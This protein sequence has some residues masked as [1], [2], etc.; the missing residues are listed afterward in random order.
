MVPSGSPRATSMR[1][2]PP[3]SG[4]VPRSR[5]STTSS[6]WSATRTSRPGTITTVDDEDL[7]TVGDCRISS[8]GWG[9]PRRSAATGRLGR[10]R[11]GVRRASGH[12]RRSGS[13]SYDER[14]SSDATAATCSRPATTRSSG[15]GLQRRRRCRDARPRGRRPIGAKPDRTRAG[16]RPR[17]A[18]RP[19]GALGHGCA[20]TPPAR[21]GAPP[22]ST[23][24][25][26][27][28]TA[29]ASRRPNP[30][31]HPWV[32]AGAPH[33]LICAIETARG[34]LAATEIATRPASAISRWAGSTC[35][36][37]STPPT[38]TCRRSTCARRLVGSRAARSRSHRSIASSH[39][40]RRRRPA[41]AG[42]LAHSLGF[43][44]KSAI[45]PRQLSVASRGL[46][47][48][49]AGARLGVRGARTP[50]R[51]AG[52][53]ALRLPDGDFVDVHS[54]SGP[55]CAAPRRC[56]QRADAVSQRLAVSA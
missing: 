31:R 25:P 53:A 26:T 49:R 47:P 39:A 24:S 4:P 45:H 44:G 7:G 36:V 23:P 2:C 56:P 22:T 41:L 11:R 13:P 32:A 37:T 9:Q 42:E 46:H 40:R 35:V 28:P 29:S 16:R 48:R 21:G 19:A 20:S 18:G 30:R 51:R 43:F 38:A 15:P 17:R 12:R 33:S 52:G 8:S 34:V 5:R 54:A 55:P 3:S 14:A 50:S 10:Q 6:R 1:S 27:S